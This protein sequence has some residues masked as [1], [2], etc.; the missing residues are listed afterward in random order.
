MS[1]FNSS[2]YSCILEYE[3]LYEIYYVIDASRTEASRP[4][5]LDFSSPFILPSL[6]SQMAV[7]TC[8]TMTDL[9][10]LS[11]KTKTD[12]FLTVVNLMENVLRGSFHFCSL[13]S[14]H[15]LTAPLNLHL[16][17]HPGMN[18]FALVVSTTFL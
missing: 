18:H 10:L 7:Y 6:A 15:V 1:L 11:Y 3:T 17:F 9:T 14:L 16:T 5:G 2:G 13:V 8:H 4:K 12:F